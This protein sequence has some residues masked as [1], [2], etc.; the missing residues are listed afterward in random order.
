MT[1]QSWL[2]QRSLAVLLMLAEPGSVMM[3]EMKSMTSE[4]EALYPAFRS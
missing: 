2:G 3:R 4:P 1:V